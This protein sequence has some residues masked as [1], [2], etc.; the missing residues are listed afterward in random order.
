MPAGRCEDAEG[1]HRAGL[2]GRVFDRCRTPALPEANEWTSERRS[3]VDRGGSWPTDGDREFVRKFERHL[4]EQPQPGRGDERLTDPGVAPV[5]P[6]AVAGGGARTSRE[7]PLCASRGGSRVCGGVV[8]TQPQGLVRRAAGGMR[9][10][11][12]RVSTRAACPGR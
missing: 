8:A 12:R 1:A 11:D 3:G 4:D 2:Q 6:S 5:W 7:P 10:A 9:C